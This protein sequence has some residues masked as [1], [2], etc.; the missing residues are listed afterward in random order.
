M[1]EL[2]QIK[3]FLYKPT[4]QQWIDNALNNK[5]I[6]LVDHAH[7]EKK[8]AS[9]A[10][11]LIYRYPD[12]P[13]LLQKMSKLAREELRHFEQVI[14]ILTQRQIPF[15]PLEA[16]GYV[17]GLREQAR[18]KEPHRL[19]DTLIIGAFIEARSCERF[20]CLY[21]RLEPEL[22]QFYY[23]LLASEA[24]HFQDYLALAARYSPEP[25]TD[26]IAFF[27][28]L[29]SELITKPDTLFR[30][31]SGPILPPFAPGVLNV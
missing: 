26:R 17:K 7:C 22:S 29:E 28:E 21:P 20:A 9:S 24:R 2:V 27:A 25:L 18:D 14:T 4:C 10:L 3:R 15:E 23:R 30:F 31:H 11:A 6:L 5:H 1:E 13:E 16:S 12:K 8:A 19:V